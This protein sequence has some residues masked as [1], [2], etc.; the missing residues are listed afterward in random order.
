MITLVRA[1]FF[2]GISLCLLLPTGSTFSLVDPVTV[3]AG[4]NDVVVLST[5]PSSTGVDLVV[6]TFQVPDS[7]ASGTTIPLK[8][9]SNG[10]DSNAI[11]LF[12]Q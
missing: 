12:I 6:V 11:S 7:L 8:V 2:F 9:T 1:L 3:T 4:T 5:V 10:V